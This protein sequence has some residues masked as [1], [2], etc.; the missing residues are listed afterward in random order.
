MIDRN[1]QEVSNVSDSFVQQANGDIHNYG[2]AYTDV[3]EICH[4]VVRQELAI[5]TKEATDIFHKEVAAFEDQFVERLEKLE[6]P[7]VIDKLRTPKLQFALHDTIKEY[8]K[9]DDANTKEELIDLLIDRL[10]VN[11]H[12]SEQYLIDESIKILPNLSLAQTYFLGALTLRKIVNRGYS[13][14]VDR[15]LAKRAMLYEYLNEITTLDI[16][17]LKL[18]KC[19]SDMPGT[20]YFIPTLNAMKNNYDLLFR[21][22]ITDDV[23]YTFLHDHPNLPMLNGRILIYKN[24]STNESHLLYSSKKYLIEELEQAHQQFSLSELDNFINIFTPLSDEEMK[25]YL[26]SLN[27]NWQKALECL[28][29]EEI[30]QIDL[31][32]VGLYIGRRI[33]KKVT[34]DVTLPLE[35]FYK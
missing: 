34:K 21:H 24:D 17:Y 33:V 8:A 12:S 23:L 19:C 25:Q 10:N 31:T 28:D 22:H 15:N 26:I 3:K 11:E 7:Q 1:K 9:S 6:N 29:R 30:T 13:Y 18:V 35:D 2:L 32:P 5:V 20:K 4:D 27:P 14:I 16:Q